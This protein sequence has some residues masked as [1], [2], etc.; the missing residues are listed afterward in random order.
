LDETETDWEAPADASGRPWPRP[1]SLVAEAVVVVVVVVGL[2]DLH[3][4]TTDGWWSGELAGRYV[5]RSLDMEVALT[6][7]RAIKRLIP[8]WRRPPEDL[9]AW[10]ASVYSSALKTHLTYDYPSR[11]E[12]KKAQA[13]LAV[14]L[15]E[16][17][18]REAA[19]EALRALISTPPSTPRVDAFA[20]SVVQAY[21]LQGVPTGGDAPPIELPPGWSA[22][23]LEVRLARA[24]GDLS[25]CAAARNRIMTRGTATLKWELASLAIDLLF[26]C[27]GLVALLRLILR[28]H[29]PLPPLQTP[30]TLQ[31]GL[32]TVVL[33][34][35]WTFA[36]EYFL[37]FIRL[38]RGPHLAA[39]ALLIV[40]LPWFVLVRGR[41]LRP[42]GASARLTFGLDGWTRRGWAFAMWVAAACAVNLLGEEAIGYF[43]WQ[44]ADGTFL[45][46]DLVFGS[47]F[48]V[49]ARGSGSM[50]IGPVVEEVAFRGILYG[51]LR[52]RLSPLLAALLSSLGFA[53]THPYGLAS[54]AGV[55]WTGFVLCLV[56]ERSRSLVPA[57]AAHMLLNALW[58]FNVVTVFR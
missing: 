13:R 54:L 24:T 8:T 6:Q 27:A 45:D 25:D 39:W 40:P 21:G 15:A 56:Y 3:R 10:A 7:F 26:T 16:F 18:R 46:A 5:E 9:G 30:W 52:N 38:P 48:Q 19:A 33:A 43:A 41:L 31:A 23:T 37:E 55:A 44:T 42:L 28:R 4:T 35:F 57:I 53:A 20:K 1:L 34:F 12:T 50:V 51:S 32:W 17:D 29:P 49:A 2:I 22:D 36:A 11:A 14:A 47:L 58:F